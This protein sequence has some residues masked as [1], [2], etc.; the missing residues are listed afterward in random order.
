GG[1]V[2]VHRLRHA[3]RGRGGGPRGRRAAARRAA[4]GD[5]GGGRRMIDQREYLPAF[6]AEAREHLQ[7]LG[8]AILR[9]EAAPDDRI[10]SEGVFRIAHSLK[11]MSATMGYE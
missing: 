6:L 1:G 10:A 3:A 9:I 5:R 2:D 4:R 7:D 8:L 11:G